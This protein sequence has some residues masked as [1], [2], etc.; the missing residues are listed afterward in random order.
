MELPRHEGAGPDLTGINE[1]QRLFEVEHDERIEPV[2]L[3][4]DITQTIR[5][6]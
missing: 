1:Q 6:H 4:D 5:R 3:D 2:N